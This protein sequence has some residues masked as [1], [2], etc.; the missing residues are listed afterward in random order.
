MDGE[1]AVLPSLGALVR[2]PK[3]VESLRPALPA[4]L[5]TFDRIAAELDQTRF[6]FV[7]LQPEL[8]KPRA[9]F[10]QT[11]D[12]LAVALETDREVVRIAHD[13][14]IT[15]AAVFPPPFDPQVEHIVQEY[16]RK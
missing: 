7:Q 14:H 15:A 9:E 4:P 8:G 10:L 11:R 2:E 12:G 1:P 5:S 16:V 6:P 3:E 13:D